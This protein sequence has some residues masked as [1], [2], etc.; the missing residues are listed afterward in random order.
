LGLMLLNVRPAPAQ[1]ALPATSPANRPLAT[2]ATT[3]WQEQTVAGGEA[4]AAA[5]AEAEFVGSTIFQSGF[6]GVRVWGPLLVEA[7][8]FGMED[9][10]AGVTGL[11]WEFRHR[12]LRI[13]PGLAWTFSSKNRPGPA[14][15]VRWGVETASW[16]SQGLW[17]VSLR[18]G[19][20]E[21]ENR[22][23]HESE[24]DT[25]AEVYAHI[26]DGVHV[27]RRFGRWEPV[28]C[29]STSGTA[30]KTS[31]RAARAWRGRSGA[32]S[33]LSPR[34]WH[35]I[36]SSASDSPGN[37]N[38]WHWRRMMNSTHWTHGAVL[39]QHASGIRLGAQKAHVGPL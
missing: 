24:G 39:F 36:P 31:G 33:K 3:F 8:Y 1:L 30:T 32:G 10:D 20:F 11:S 27:I 4:E 21:P 6:F 13:L 5:P 2:E 34:P 23:A 38:S 14:A 12:G 17:A 19:T 22:G 7:H 16:V 26:L 29:S 35:R 15:T 25:N 28:R 9:T 37:H 18:A